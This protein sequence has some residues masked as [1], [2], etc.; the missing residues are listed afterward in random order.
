MLTILSASEARAHGSSFRTKAPRGEVVV[1]GD[2]VD[3]TTVWLD[4]VEVG[5]G[6]VVFLPDAEPWLLD[7]I[8]AH[9]TP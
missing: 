5:A 7:R 2:D 1:V 3:D 6:H 9:R 4:A 8:R